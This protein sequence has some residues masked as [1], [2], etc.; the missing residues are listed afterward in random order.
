MEANK[1]TSLS[2]AQRDNL[3]VFA[4]L[5]ATSELINH[6]ILKMKFESK[7]GTSELKG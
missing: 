4:I 2:K 6:R 5:E 1:D 3:G 7:A